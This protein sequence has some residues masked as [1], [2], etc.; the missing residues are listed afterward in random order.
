MEEFPGGGKEGRK[1]GLEDWRE[2]RGSGERPGLIEKKP[3]CV[4]REEK[5]D[6]YLY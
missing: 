4:W 3:E 1:R 6:N 2:E 5:A